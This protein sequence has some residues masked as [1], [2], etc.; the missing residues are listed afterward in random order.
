VELVAHLLLLVGAD[1]ALAEQAAAVAAIGLAIAAVL[2][3]LGLGGTDAGQ[4]TAEYVGVTALTLVIVGG[5]AWSFGLGL[6][7]LYVRIA[8]EL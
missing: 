7:D 5:V 6:S 8:A 4:P 3:A 2:R 1:P